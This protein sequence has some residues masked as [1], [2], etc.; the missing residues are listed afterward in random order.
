MTTLNIVAPAAHK[1]RRALKA[2]A[3]LAILQSAT[4]A[5]ID[6]HIDTTFATLNVAQRRT[7]KLLLLAVSL[8][9]RERGVTA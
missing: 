8:L 3:L 9:L 6:A 4:P 1:E 2:N 5:Q 7:L